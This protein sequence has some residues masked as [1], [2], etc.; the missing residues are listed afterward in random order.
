VVQINASHARKGAPLPGRTPEGETS[1]AWRNFAPLTNSKI[2]NDKGARCRVEFY[3]RRQD[4]SRGRKA[5]P[6]AAV[7]SSETRSAGLQPSSIRTMWT[8]RSPFAD[9]GT[10]GAVVLAAPPTPAFAR[11]VDPGAINWHGGFA[12]AEYLRRRPHRGHSANGY[13]RHDRHGYGSRRR[14]N[15]SQD[16][17]LFLYGAIGH[18][19]A[20][21][22]GIPVRRVVVPVPAAT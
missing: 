8:R 20:V 5:T 10:P 21:T 2:P 16:F 6:S 4:R 7:E 17:V 15:Y 22:P 11:A 1:R 12:W 19:G 3:C 13:R 9:G 18:P 14:R